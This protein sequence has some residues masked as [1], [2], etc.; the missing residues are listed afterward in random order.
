MSQVE[1]SAKTGVRWG[2][3]IAG[4]AVLTLM[5]S[6]FLKGME[7]SVQYYMTVS[8]YIENQDSYEDRP[9][10]IQGWVQEGSLHQEGNRYEFTV[11]EGGQ[12]LFVSYVGVAP[13][14]FGDDAEVV[15]EGNGQR[16]HSFQADGMMAK[17]ASKYEE[18]GM[19]PLESLQRNN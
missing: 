10:K 18:D 3:I 16:G 12:E 15:L 9:V 19:P 8:E 7:G 2:W 11:E 13:D 1:A 17:C 4:L 14:T 5:F 6:F